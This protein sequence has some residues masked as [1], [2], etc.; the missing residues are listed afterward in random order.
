MGDMEEGEHADRACNGGLGATLA[1]KVGAG[2]AWGGDFQAKIYK[3][4]LG[5]EVGG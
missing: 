4:A 5:G 3:E 1:P 2:Q